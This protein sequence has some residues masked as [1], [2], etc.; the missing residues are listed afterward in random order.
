MP[1]RAAASIQRKRVNSH[2]ILP[3][4]SHV[5]SAKLDPGKLMTYRC[6]F[7]VVLHPVASA[8]KAQTQTGL[9][10]TYRK[11]RIVCSRDKGRILADRRTETHDLNRERFPN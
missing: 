7:R 5:P 11:P 2:S 1:V 4:E 8:P 10:A 3:A 6:A 9:R